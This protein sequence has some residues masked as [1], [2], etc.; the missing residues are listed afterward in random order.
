MVNLSIHSP[1]RHCSGIS[2]V[3]LLVTIS[4][5]GVIATITALGVSGVNR[6]AQHNKLNSDVQT[7]NS[8]IKM[9]RANG[10]DLSGISDSNSVLA[11]LKS[12]LSKE[13]KARHVGAPSGRM[14]DNRVVAVPVSVDNWKLR[15]NYDAS[16]FRFEVKESGPG[17]EF[18][19]DPNL[20][21]LAVTIEK[22]DGSAVSYAKNA[23]WIWDHASTK[24]PNA[25]AGPS[26][27][28]TKP[29][30]TD[31]TPGVPTGGGS[32]SGSGSSGGGGSTTSPPPGPP[33]PPKPPKLAT[34]K[35]SKSSGAH[36]EDDFPL[37][38]SITNMPSAAD[39]DV[40]YQIG[41][42]SWQSWSGPVTIQMNENLRAQFM[43]K[44]S[45][46]H[47]DSSQAYANFYPVA[48]S[49]SGT[50]DGNFH[51]PKGGPTLKYTISSD[52]DRFEHGDPVFVL[53]GEPINSGE[54]NTLNF[55]AKS[56]ASVPP[57]QKFKLGDLF[58]HNGSSYYD[59]HATNVQLAMV[60]EMPDRG[61]TVT[62][63]LNLDLVNTENDP[64][65]ANA[66]A[67]YVRIT[68]LQQNIG[69]KINGISYQMR[70]E[71]GATDSFG[72]STNSEFHVYEGATGQGEVLATF[73]AN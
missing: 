1:K 32:S 64:D 58:Y 40:I 14:V 45:A 51:S 47:R 11:K 2:M 33:K 28:N 15:A 55:T 34:P 41:S 25:A 67:D 31:S 20:N 70:L 30:V 50:A 62:F 17:V 54:T 10:G 18:A 66:S 42:G 9:Y 35:F 4:A 37:S 59:S 71:F 16:N 60:I 39:A 7:L 48:G 72:F 24:N 8:A 63:N 26:T 53:D 21:E 23:S 6:S 69:L 52:G 13:D 56:F 61:E 29:D 65:D 27:F 5:I 57:D 3:E 46:A 73:I 36:P 43:A 68:N 49:F 22:R 38:V 44:D 19:L 12:S